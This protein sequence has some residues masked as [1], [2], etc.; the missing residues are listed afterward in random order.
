MTDSNRIAVTGL[1]ALSSI[2]KN[3]NEIWDSIVAKKTNIVLNKCF[4]GDDLWEEFYIHK[5]KKFSLNEFIDD[6][7][8]VDWIAEWKEGRRDLDFELFASIVGQA[9][10]SG[11]IN[12]HEPKYNTGLI[13]VHENQGLESFVTTVID[14]TCKLIKDHLS[15]GEKFDRLHIFKKINAACQKE[16]YDTQSFM[17]LFFIAKLFNIHGFSLFTNN[18]CASGLYAVETAAQQI[19]SGRVSKMIV[20]GVDHAEYAYKYCWFKNLNLYATDGLI[21]PFALN[22]NGFIFGEGGAALLLERYEEAV[23]RNAPIYAEYLGGGFSLESS[24]V[25]LPNVASDL[26]SRAI[27][28]ALKYS[29]LQS[30]QIDVINP[31][32]IGE[33]ITD[34][35]EAISI[36]RVFG[37]KDKACVTAFKPYVGHN[38]GSSALL[39][40]CILILSLRNNFV[41]A[42]LNC[43][44]VDPKIKLNLVRSGISREISIGL[45]LSCGFAGYNGAVV[46][47]K[48]ES[49]G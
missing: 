39:E 47:K 24:K 35:H 34:L 2:G 27:I 44:E 17:H 4:V 45:K 26:Y 40:L 12:L 31:H 21:K 38:L 28:E 16:G 33:N 49:G 22:R 3:P 42:I 32:A 14:E 19:R 13:L 30:S 5:L 23:K 9:L 6:L 25:S 18:A 43:D 36:S 41:P 15:R 7:S 37:K 20:A 8:V 48:H 46:L 29:N 11:G 10:K 1:G